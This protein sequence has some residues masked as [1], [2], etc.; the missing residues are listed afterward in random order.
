MSAIL[1]I[2]TCHS[3][4]GVSLKLS[5]SSSPENRKIT[6]GVVPHALSFFCNAST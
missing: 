5:K 4:A 3:P 6:V 1:L 2:L